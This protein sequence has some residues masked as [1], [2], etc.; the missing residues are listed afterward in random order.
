MAENCHLEKIHIDMAENCHYKRVR[1]KRGNGKT[2][3]EKRKKG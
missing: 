1:L 2:E 3:T